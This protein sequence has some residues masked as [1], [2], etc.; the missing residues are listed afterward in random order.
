MHQSY[1][2]RSTPPPHTLTGPHPCDGRRDLTLLRARFPSVDFTLA[3]LDLKRQQRHFPQLRTVLRAA[4]VDAVA[5]RPPSLIPPVTTAVQKMESLCLSDCGPDTPDTPSPRH[6]PV[7]T[8]PAPQ[9]PTISSTCNG[10]TLDTTH[11][12]VGGTSNSSMLRHNSAGPFEGPSPRKVTVE[13]SNGELMQVPVRPFDAQCV[14]NGEDLVWQALRAVDC[15]TGCYGEG[16][17]EENVCARGVQLIEWLAR[18]YVEV[19]GCDGGGSS[20][21]IVEL[22]QHTV[23]VHIVWACCYVHS[24][25]MHHSLKTMVPTKALVVPTSTPTIV[26]NHIT[27]NCTQSYHPITS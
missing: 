9:P 27:H 6:E 16:E 15:P 3:E 17:S 21:H 1:R 4:L 12:H 11:H 14:E 8:P 24:I 13:T 2:T 20:G 18:R 26:P 25:C 19:V 5:P 7:N 10:T 22:C 23:H